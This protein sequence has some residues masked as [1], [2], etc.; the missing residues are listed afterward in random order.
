RQ[1]PLAGILKNDARIVRYKEGDIVIRKGDYGNTAFLVISGMLRVVVSPDLPE[2]LLGR[3]AVSRRQGFIEAFSRFINKS[4]YAEVR[5]TRTYAQ[6]RARKDIVLREKEAGREGAHINL[7]NVFET[8]A[9]YNTLVL[10][11]HAIIGEIG[12]LTRAAR[13]ATV[14]AQA[15][16]T[17]LEIRWQGLRDISKYAENWRRVIEKRYR[18]NT[19]K[20][21]LQAC[22]IF[23]GLDEATLRNI[24]ANVLFESFGNVESQATVPHLADGADQ[25]PVISA[26]GDYADGV[27]I[28][29]SGFARVSVALGNGRR[30]LTTLK[31]GNYYGL[32]EL[33]ETWR[34]GDRVPLETTLSALGFVDAIRVPTHVLEA[35]V[36]PNMQ[37]PKKRL[38]DASAKPLADDPLTEWAV[39][40]HFINGT[41]AMLVDL[42][43]CV[44]CDDCV[45]A[46]AATHG[47]NP[48][49]VRHGKTFDHWMVANACMHCVDAVCLIGCPTGAIH[50]TLEGGMVVINDGTCIG[51][52]VCA[53]S[54]PY[55]NIRMVEI[56]DL[57]GRPVLDPEQHTPILK[58]TKCDLCSGL[59]AGP[60]CARACPHGAL[61][62][63]DF[64][65]IRH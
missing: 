40:E 37:A 50:R 42:D 30:T 52:G 64:N 49:F 6:R 14:V 2:E 10:E 38:S 8:L 26:E 21:V 47:G 3:M 61:Q 46:C 9:G 55:H 45:T 36:F 57:K 35:Y 43:R 1:T 56:R 22:P 19:P 39:A 54:C 59:P 53:N 33:Y 48:R 12:A 25:E 65:E 4:K 7:P 11:K 34:S 27:L 17:L 24:A 16:S 32:D 62:R 41:K 63:V 29:G 23:A 31:T 51:C 15:D 44:R 60:A 5:D 28:I 18:E 58:A 20:T 13:T